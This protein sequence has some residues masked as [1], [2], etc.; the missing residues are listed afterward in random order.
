MEQQFRYHC[1]C[2]VKARRIIDNVTLKGYN[3]SLTAGQGHVVTKID[4]IAYKSIHLAETNVLTPI[5]RL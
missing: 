1:V 5:P 3:R 2:L 4:H